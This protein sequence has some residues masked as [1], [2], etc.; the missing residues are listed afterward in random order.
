M[1]D[2]SVTPTEA[3]LMNAVVLAAM[4]EALANGDRISTTLICDR[5]YPLYRQGERNFDRLKSA[6][7]GKE[8]AGGEAA[9]SADGSR[10]Q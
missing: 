9:K 10:S 7:L 2:I 6:A 3:R 4:D 5:V 1:M 8:I